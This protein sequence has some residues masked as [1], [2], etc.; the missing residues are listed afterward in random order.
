MDAK[1]D[2]LR[3]IQTEDTHDRFCIDDISAGYQIKIIIKF[4]DIVYE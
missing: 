3:K 4:C 1:I 2:R